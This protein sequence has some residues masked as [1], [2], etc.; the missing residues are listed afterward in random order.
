MK[1]ALKEVVSAI[2]NGQKV[3]DSRGVVYKQ[4]FGEKFLDYLKKSLENNDLEELVSVLD[5]LVSDVGN[6]LSENDIEWQQ[7]GYYETAK[8]LLKRLRSN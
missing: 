7:A 8:V 4:E 6:L 1:K 3:E 5:G 2:E